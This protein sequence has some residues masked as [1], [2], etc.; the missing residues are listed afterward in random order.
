MQTIEQKQIKRWVTTY[1]NNS[2]YVQ[3]SKFVYLY[4]VSA[5]L[6]GNCF[7][8]RYYSYTNRYLQAEK[9]EN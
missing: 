8:I 5:K 3:N 7:L 9:I 1:K 6:K 4:K 2:G